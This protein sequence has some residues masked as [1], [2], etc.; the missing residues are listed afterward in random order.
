MKLLRRLHL[1]LG[2]LFAP[3]LLYYCLSGASQALGLTYRWKDGKN[4]AVLLSEFSRPHK[5]MIMPGAS[6]SDTKKSRVNNR[7]ESY[8]YFAVAMSLGIS[9]TLILG[10]VMA[11]KFFR[12]R[13]AVTAILSAGLLVP[14]L[15]L[16]S[17]V[18]EWRWQEAEAEEKNEE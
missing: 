5:T 3:L 15:M 7:S 9:A 13:W 6:G 18:K 4:Q 11:Y 10:I 1:L 16:W 14:T 8:K 2:C 12:P 17:S